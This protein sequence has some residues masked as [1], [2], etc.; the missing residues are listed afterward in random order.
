MATTRLPGQL[1]RSGSIPPAA[2]GGGVISASAQLATSL[3]TGTVSSST[4]IDYNSITNKL[5]GV[6]SS[7]AQ[8]AP[9]LPINTISGSTQ[10]KTLTDPFT[11][12]FTGSF[13]G[14]GTNLTGIAA[15]LTF[16][17]STSGTDTLN[18]KT[19]GLIFSGSNG[20]TATVTNNTVTLT[21]PAGTV[22]ASS[23]VDYNNIQNKLSGVVSSSAQVAPLLP[24]GTVSSS[25]QV[26]ITA[27]TGYSTFSSSLATVDATQQVSL[28]ALNTATSSYAIN[29]TIQGQ[30]AGVVSSSTQVKPLL[31]GGTVTSSAQYPGWITAS[32][33]V[34]YNSITNKLSGVVS[35]STQVPP[36]LPGGTVSSSAQ[37]LLNTV[38][39]TTFSNNAFYFPTDL[40]VEG[41][42]TAQQIY[43]EYVSS[44]VIYESGSTKF[45]D[46][47]DDVMSVTGSIRVLGGSISG[48][49]TG[50]FS[51]SAQVDYN[52]I[53]NKLSGV[54]SS[55]A[56]VAPLLPGGTVSSSG[57]VDITATTGY[58]TF[59]SSIA[60]KNNVQD[61]SIT[62]LNTATSSYAINST[63][64]SQLAGVVSSSTQVKPLLPGGTVTSS[65]QYP[66]W[67]TSSTQV[68][69]SSVNYN[70]GIM[71][72]S[73][74]TV[75]N[76]IGQTVTL[77]GS[78]FAS[79]V[80]GSGTAYRLVVPVG[81]NLYAT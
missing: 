2:L 75:T 56:Q 28:T 36:L 32:S 12:S 67:V 35:S 13:T 30:L 10:F 6:V 53:T 27:T 55:S 9:L 81:T 21:A 29:S 5:S 38:S 51:S 14:D 48:S 79:I 47:T 78:Q 24:G 69:W 34:D 57:Q 46:T 54:V 22:S 3:P 42:L 16:S 65:A 37:V 31:P 44:S 64:Q 72:S 4:Q 68:V 43:T 60:T 39:G 76:L 18:L 40:R 77:S 49:M 45:G 20:I 15:T 50:M 63:L 8:V 52:S 58:S 19:E 17:G 70:T 23:Q 11:G 41:N 80:S 1:I 26:D 62:A 66:G 7:S 61:V 25:A 33:Q 59:S 74:Q 73:A 71:S